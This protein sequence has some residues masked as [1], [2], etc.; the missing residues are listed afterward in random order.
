MLGRVCRPSGALMFGDAPIQGLT[1][2]ATDCRPFGTELSPRPFGGFVAGHSG[3]LNVNPYAHSVYRIACIIKLVPL[4]ELR[5]RATMLPL[6]GT[7]SK[8]QER[9]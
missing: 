1:P 4:I 9:G 5:L 3:P 7:C 2:L 8:N 6:L